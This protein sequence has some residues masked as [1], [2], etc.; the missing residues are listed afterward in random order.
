MLTV[1]LILSILNSIGLGYILINK[2][3]EKF[4]IVDIETYSTLLD[5]WAEHHDD[6]GNEIARELAGGTGIAVGFGADYL[7]D[8]EEYEEEE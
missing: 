8:D 5:Y 3:K 4:I 1:I 7:E 2:F 6:E